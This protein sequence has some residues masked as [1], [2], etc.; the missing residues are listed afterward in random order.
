MIATLARL[1]PTPLKSSVFAATLAGTLI[2]SATVQAQEA[3]WG[4]WRGPQYN[5]SSLTAK[6]P[7]KFSDTENLLWKVE[8]PGKGSSTPIIWDN[9]VL[10]LTAV[11]TG[12]E[13]PPTLETAG[14][15]PQRR[16]SRPATGEREPANA[17]IELDDAPASPRPSRRGRGSRAPTTVHDFMI[18]SY[19]KDTGRELWRRNLVSTV[20]HEAGHRTNNFASTSPVTDGK[21]IYVN[22]G[23]RGIYCLDMQGNVQWERDYGLMRT[24][25]GFGEGASPALYEDTLIVPWDQEEQSMLLALDTSTGDEKWR[26]KRDEPTTWATPLITKS[27]ETVQVITNGTQVRS[28]NL[29]NGDLIW[30]CGGQA[31]NPIPAPVLVD[32]HVIC[33]TGYRGY[34]IVSTRIDSE[35]DVTDSEEAVAWTAD[36][37]APY[38]PSP[39]LWDGK[40]YFCKGFT[41]VISARDA[42]T[43]E[44]Y[45]DQERLPHVRDI[46]ASPVAADGRIY[47]CGRNGTVVVIKPGPTLEVLANNEMNEEMDASPAI[48]GNRMYLRGE[49]HL[50]CVGD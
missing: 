25:N 41:N 30:E 45:L 26:V 50:F 28:Y 24:R 4:N 23:S 31:S 38:V 43:G 32:D 2:L 17:T 29:E 19:D 39:V 47:F 3:N 11:D 27:G 22:F 16:P 1:I 10:V 9:Q 33:M 18:L 21:N 35:G 34:A 20:P 40:L 14:E 8:I 15:E 42:R 48:I 13:A 36:D 44:T 6:P 5:G 12:K 46:Y 37:A 49:K 7:L